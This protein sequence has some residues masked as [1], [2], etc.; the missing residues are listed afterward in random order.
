MHSTCLKRSECWKARL[1][2][3]YLSYSAHEWLRYLAVTHHYEIC[4]HGR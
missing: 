3:L 4:N 2:K 1:H